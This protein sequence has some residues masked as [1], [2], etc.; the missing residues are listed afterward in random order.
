MRIL[1]LSWRLPY[2][3]DCGGR[4]RAYNLLRAL[5]QAHEISL[6]SLMWPTESSSS[7]EALKAFC[8]DVETVPFEPLVNPPG[9][10]N[11]LAHRLR[12]WM[13]YFEWYSHTMDEQVSAALGRRHY[14]L[15]LAM[16]FDSSPYI[17]HLEGIPKVLEEL[18]FGLLKDS[19]EH[20]GFTL[21]GLRLRWTWF[22]FQ[23]KVRHLCQHIE[24]CTVASAIEMEHL[25]HILPGYDRV[26]VIP[27]GVDIEGFQFQAASKEAYTLIFT[28]PLTYWPNYDALRYF[29]RHIYPIIKRRLPDITLTVT[30]SIAGV[31]LSGLPLDDGVKILGYVNDVRPLVASS[32]VA[33]VPLR[34]GG[35]TRLKI[36]EAMALG[37]PVVSTS[38][39]AEGLEVIPGQHL[40]I[41][42]DPKGFAEAC[43]SLLTDRSMSQRLAVAARELVEARYD[44]QSIGAKLEQFLYAV[45]S[46]G[47][48]G[49]L[50]VVAEGKV[51]P[52]TGGKGCRESA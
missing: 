52:N 45:L 28:G 3:P 46:R 16:G 41:A 37:T 7:I 25:H 34:L 33:I 19:Y 22:K 6:I 5:S 38:K 30:G 35:G 42:D 1:A 43:I 26:H 8:H 36:I 24:G 40:L 10:R 48:E 13:S 31:D 12:R 14:D 51:M 15:V 29:L 17:E 2:P 20:E 23:K 21:T 9:L 32:S 44:W 47:K 4:I 27:N 39:G 49:A 11:R 18:E 50:E